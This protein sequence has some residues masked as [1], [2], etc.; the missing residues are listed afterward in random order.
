MHHFAVIAA[1]IVLA[2]ALRGRGHSFHWWVLPVAL[3]LHW[4]LWQGFGRTPLFL[5]ALI[6]FFVAVIVSA[7]KRRN[8]VP[9]ASLPPTWRSPAQPLASGAGS[10]PGWTE[11]MRAEGRARPRLVPAPELPIA[12]RVSDPRPAMPWLPE[13]PPDAAAP[14]PA[15]SGPPSQGPEHT[16]EAT[17]RLAQPRRPEWLEDAELVEPGTLSREV[18]P[19]P[20]PLGDLTGARDASEDALPMAGQGAQLLATLVPHASPRQRAELWPQLRADEEIVAAPQGMT[21][22]TATPTDGPWGAATVPGLRLEWDP[23]Q[24]RPD[25]TVIVLRCTGHDLPGGRHA[26]LVLVPTSLGGVKRVGPDQRWAGRGVF[27]P[28]H[29]VLGEDHGGGDPDLNAAGELPGHSPWAYRVNPP[30]GDATS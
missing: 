8:P 24:V 3:A 30:D 20:P 23:V 26:A 1:L 17:P 21:R 18:P 4:L 28:L 16:S 5:G 7:W 6:G 14:E 12:P 22:V 9:I 10:A 2:L 27:V 11:T 25:V 29:L 15:R 13:Q 19:P